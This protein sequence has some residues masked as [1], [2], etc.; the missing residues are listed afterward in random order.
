MNPTAPESLVF[1]TTIIF[2]VFFILLRKFAW[3]PILGAVKGR[4]ESINNAL[5]S[6]E[7]ARKEMQ[8]LTAD[9]ERILH[10]ARMERDA[11]LKEAREMRDKMI[12]D[13][14]H[15]AQIQGERMIEQAKTAIEAEKN[16]AMAELK[17]QVSS[18]SLEIAEKLL[19]DELS[20]K[21]AQ[22]KLVEKMLGDVKL[23]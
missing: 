12:A 1:W 13:S 22:T 6:A 18:L 9:N 21:E 11:L 14:K 19:K 4:E 16:A 23:N 15:E 3:K 10:E 2:I 17:S 8:N 20:N 7:A 5:A